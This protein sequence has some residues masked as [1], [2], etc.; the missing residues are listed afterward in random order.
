MENQPTVAPAPKVPPDTAG[1]FVA[2]PLDPKDTLQKMLDGLDLQASV[3]QTTEDGQILLQI[4]TDEAGRLIGKQGQAL[5]QLQFL[6]N[7]ILH[8]ADPAAQRVIVDCE[9]YHQRQHDELIQKVSEAADKVRRWGEPLH[10]GPFNAFDRRLIHQHF[11]ND[12]EIEAVSEG[13]EPGEQGH[14]HKRMT[15]RIKQ[16]PSN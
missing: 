4:R 8:R 1:A 3:E 13:E 15:F 10:F 2:N 7:R 12:P 5:S 14:G 11:A 6:L 9:N 16:T